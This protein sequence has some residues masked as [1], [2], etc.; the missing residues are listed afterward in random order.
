MKHH[1]V[2]LTAV[3]FLLLGTTLPALA[4][5]ADDG[6]GGTAPTTP[7]TQPQ[8]TRVPQGKYQPQPSRV[9]TAQREA[10]PPRAPLAQN[11]PQP[12]RAPLSPVPAQPPRAQN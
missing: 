6:K 4:Q 9:P 3:L 7:Q 12:T 1:G 8:P 10:Q 2:L 11:Q 5:S